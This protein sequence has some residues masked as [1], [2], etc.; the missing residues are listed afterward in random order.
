M[1][2]VEPCLGGG[3][4]GR[5][6]GPSPEAGACRVLANAAVLCPP[7]SATPCPSTAPGSQQELPRRREAGID[8]VLSRRD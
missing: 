3:G 8:A 6:L 5:D 2:N 4:S 7:P 1:E